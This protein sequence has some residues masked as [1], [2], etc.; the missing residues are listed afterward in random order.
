[1]PFW[2][3]TLY[4]VAHAAKTGPLPELLRSDIPDHRK[5]HTFDETNNSLY[6]QQPYVLA[7]LPIRQ[8]TDWML[9]E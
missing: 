7:L 1:V 8:C 6:M 3:H 9:V 4:F 5:R 2:L